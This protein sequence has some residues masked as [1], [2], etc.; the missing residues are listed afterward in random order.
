VVENS[1][2]LDADPRIDILVEDFGKRSQP[3]RKQGE[4]DREN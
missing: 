1:V 3:V 2:H 4:Y